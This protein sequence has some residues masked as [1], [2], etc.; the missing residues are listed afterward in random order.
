[1]SVFTLK[2]IALVTMIIDHMGVV[3]PEAFGFD[4]TFN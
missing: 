4:S 3:I 2:I 1:M